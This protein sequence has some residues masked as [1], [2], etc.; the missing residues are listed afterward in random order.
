MRVRTRNE[1]MLFLGKN[2]NNRTKECILGLSERVSLPRTI[3]CPPEAQ[4]RLRELKNSFYDD[5]MTI[6]HK[7][8]H[9]FTTMTTENL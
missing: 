5:S 9:R 8:R 2:S 1:T 6:E 7:S 3:N 4:K